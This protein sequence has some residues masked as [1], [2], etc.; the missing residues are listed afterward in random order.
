MGIKINI[1]AFA[2]IFLSAASLFA[3]EESILAR[4]TVYWPGE[5]QLRA[6][7]NGVRLRTGHVAVD[8]K[9]I[10]YGSHVIFPDAECV[11]VDSGPGVVNR[12]AARA[13]AR[14]AAQREAIVIDRFFES[15][16]SALSWAGAHP[17]Y[18]T[19]RVQ[20]A[21]SARRLAETMTADGTPKAGPGNK[22]PA[23]TAKTPA[24]KRRVG[25]A[26]L[27]EFDSTKM[28]LHLSL[29]SVLRSVRRT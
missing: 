8:P 22:V 1:T 25:E 27:P 26:S 10:P 5:G 29:D 18:M 7:S 15:K 9:R 20:S 16:A 4:I 12:T 24:T 6:C 14:T 13:C 3:R 2:F 11:A 28:E 21:E 17:Q 19:V 23:S